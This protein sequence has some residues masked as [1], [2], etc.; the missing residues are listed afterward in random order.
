M[1][2]V[3]KKIAFDADLL[4]HIALTTAH[5][6][7]SAATAS[8]MVVRD[9]SA[10]AKFAAPG[11]S[12]D[13]LIKGTRVT[14][15]EL[16]AMTDEKIWKGT[17]GNVEEVDMPAAGATLTVATTE[18]FSGTSPSSYTDLDLSG[19]VGEN[20]ALVIL[21]IYN[22]RAST[23]SKGFRANGET[24]FSRYTYDAAHSN[25]QAIATDFCMVIVHTDSGGIVEWRDSNANANSTVDIVAYIK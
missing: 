15:S 8:K 1:A 7:V 25:A 11:A 18:V 10:R 21:K 2:V 20:V 19:V 12:G 17:G 22:P 3:W 5:G 24:E 4:T 9:A 13:A 16:P 23:Q 6:A 14:V